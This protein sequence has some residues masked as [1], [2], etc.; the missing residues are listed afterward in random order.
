[1]LVSIG[2]QPGSL[3][4]FT[5]YIFPCRFADQDNGRVRQATFGSD[6]VEVFNHWI[7]P[8]NRDNLVLSADMFNDGGWPNKNA[9]AGL[10]EGLHQCAIIKFADDAWMQ[11]IHFQPLNQFGPDGNIFSRE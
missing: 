5:K 8:A 6:G 11:I 7:D 9:R 1:M 10:P 2:L 3:P 4:N